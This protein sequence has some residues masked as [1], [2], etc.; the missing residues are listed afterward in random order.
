VAALG[1]VIAL[2]TYAPTFTDSPTERQPAAHSGAVPARRAR[3]GGDPSMGRTAFEHLNTWGVT[4]TWQEYPMEH[5]VVAEIRDIHDWLSRQLREPVACLS[6]PL[7]RARFLHYTA[8]RTF[9]NQLM[10]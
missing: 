9:L 5:E 7:R 6:I 2:S 4:A 1:G 8:R 3:P 10:R